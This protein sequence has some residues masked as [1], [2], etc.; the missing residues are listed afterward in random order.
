M[1]QCLLRPCTRAVKALQGDATTHLRS[2]FHLIPDICREF[3]QSLQAALK[4]QDD[5]A[6]TLHRWLC[7]LT[8]R[9]QVAMIFSF[10]RA[11]AR[12]S[13][14][15]ARGCF[16]GCAEMGACLGHKPGGSRCYEGNE[17]EVRLRHRGRKSKVCDDSTAQSLMR[18]RATRLCR[19]D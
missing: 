2:L 3:H 13:C 10:C 18:S 15:A 9:H 11:Q 17:G 5:A 1:T 4:L 14:S 8:F 6:K 7:A 12:G 19:K 16:Q